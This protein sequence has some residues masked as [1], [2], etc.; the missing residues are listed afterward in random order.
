VIAVTGEVLID[1]VVSPGGQVHARLGGGPYNAA[2]TLARLGAEANFLGRVGADPF[3]RLLRDQLAREGVRF[4]IPE[5]SGK[6]TTLSVAT[7]GESGAAAYS[8]Y[9]DSTASPDL[10]YDVLA[11]A[12]TAGVT[13]LLIG[14]LSL[15]TEPSGTSIER[16]VAADAPEEALVVLDPNCRPAT[17]DD[18]RAYATRISALLHRTDIV[19]A[20]VEDFAYLYPSLSV[21]A[22]AN[23]LLRAGASLVLA[24]DGPRPVRAFLPDGVLEEEVPKV[25]VVDTI[26]AGDAFAGGFLAWWTAQGLGRADLMRADPSTEAGH[27][28]RADLRKANLKLDNVRRA[29]QAAIGAAALTCTR[30]GA[31]PPNLSELRA[32]NWWP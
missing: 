2:R 18:P 20:S 12:L 6:P 8:F 30:P 7:L 27:L 4:G 13:G 29:V 22:A 19:K 14:G 16:L 3:G 1:L 31:D 32:R 9:L 15:V 17:I 11:K 26:G 21:G 10:E 24:T 25:N 28:T 23:A 5:P